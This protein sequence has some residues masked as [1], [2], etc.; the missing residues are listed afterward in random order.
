MAYE[1][2]PRKEEITIKFGKGLADRSFTSKSGKSMVQVLIPNRAPNDKTRWE[3]FA[4]PANMVHDN[5]YGKGV[6]MK[7]PADGETKVSRSVPNGKDDMGRT[8]WQNTSRTVSNKELKSMMEAYKEQ[9]RDSMLDTLAQKSAE[10][11]AAPRRAANP[12]RD[13]SR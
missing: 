2:E 3:T 10:S 1:N 7:L 4:V 11:K 12:K 5:Q 9:S 13:F 8:I 6:W